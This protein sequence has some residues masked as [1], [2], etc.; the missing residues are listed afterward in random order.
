MTIAFV[1]SGAA[2]YGSLQVGALQVLLERGIQPDLLVGTSAGAMNAAYLAFDPTPEGARRLAGLWRDAARDVLS[3]GDALL[4]L[5]RLVTNQDGLLPNEPL[6]RFIGRSLPAG[7][8]RYGDLQRRA[9]GVAVRLDTGELRCFGDSPDDLIVDGLMASTAIPGFYPPW[10]CDGAA[11]V[12]GGVLSYVPVQAAIERGA[13]EV[14]ALNVNGPAIRKGTL[15]GTLAIAGRA[16]DLLVQR[17]GA[18][19]IAAYQSQPGIVVHNMALSLEREV[20]FW[21]F[22]HADEMI[23]S[24]RALAAAYL[25]GQPLHAAGTRNWRARLAE[26]RQRLAIRLRGPLPISIARRRVAVRQP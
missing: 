18:R 14:Y 20:A 1:M 2:N 9:Y 19:E 26:W 11:Y 4:M 22:R 25:D 15:R 10:L 12:D 17:Q 13:T 21:D 5:W 7:V 6:R 24:G 16:L 23:E 8:T 3:R